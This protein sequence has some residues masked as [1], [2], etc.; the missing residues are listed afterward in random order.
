[1]TD[2]PQS[3]AAAAT[4]PD[5]LPLRELTLIGTRTGGPTPEALLRLPGGKI[6]RARPGDEVA[7]LRIAAIAPGEVHVLQRGESYRLLLPGS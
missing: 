1:M 4:Q 7:G 2:A 6:T 5:R 3:P